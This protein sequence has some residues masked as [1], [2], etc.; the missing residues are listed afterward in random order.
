[1]TVQLLGY[2]G[3]VTP[4]KRPLIDVTPDIACLLESHDY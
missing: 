2:Q 4:A 1:M 3:L